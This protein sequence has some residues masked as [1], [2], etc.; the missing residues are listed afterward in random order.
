MQKSITICFIFASIFFM[1]CRDKGKDSSSDPGPATT[2]EPETE[3]PVTQYGTLVLGELRG[4]I[5]PKNG[6]DATSVSGADI[7]ALEHSELVGKTGADGAFVISNTAPGTVSLMITSNDTGGSLRLNGDTNA[8]YGLKFDD[9]TITSG[10]STDLGVTQFKETGS[11]SG[12][13]KYYNNPNNLDLTGAEVFVP[14]T[15]YIAKTDAQGEFKISGLPEGKYGLRAQQTG[16]SVLDLV[17]VEVKEAS[18]TKLGTITLSLS[19]GPEGGISSKGDATAIISQK[20]YEIFKSKSITVIL[21][22][23]GDAALMKLSDEPAFLNKSWLPVAKTFP[24]T[25]DSDGFKTIYVQY[26]DLNGLESSPFSVEL[27][28]DTTVP[29]LTGISL[30]HDWLE[31]GQLKSIV[32]V[33]ASDNGSGVAEIMFSNS[34]ANFNSGEVWQTYTGEQ[35]T[36]NIAS[37]VD[38]PR[39]VYVRVRDFAGNISTTATDD[40]TKGPFTIIKNKTYTK[41]VHL[42]KDQSP[43]TIPSSGIQIVTDLT[44]D[45]DVEIDLQTRTFETKAKVTAVGT[46]TKRIRIKNGYLISLYSLVGVSEASGYS[47]VTFDNATVRVAGGV[48]DNCIFDGTDNPYTRNFEKY[49]GDLLI[50]KNS[51]FMKW[52]EITLSY[53]AENVRLED[54]QA[55]IVTWLRVEGSGAVSKRNQLT[56]QTGI[57]GALVTVRNGTVTSESDVMNVSSNGTAYSTS[58]GA[59][60][61]ATP[62]LNIKNPTINNCKYAFHNNTN[63]DTVSTTTVNGGTVTGCSTLA[64]NEDFD[65]G[66]MQIQN[67]TATNLTYAHANDV[68]ANG[69]VNIT[70]SDIRV[71]RALGYSVAN[72]MTLNVSN[73]IV[74]CEDDGTNPCDLLLSTDMGGNPAYGTLTLTNNKIV[75][76]GD[77]VSGCRGFTADKLN[78]STT[79]DLN[80]TLSGNFWQSGAGIKSMIPASFSA[81]VTAA[82]PTA[83]DIRAYK[84]GFTTVDGGAWPPVPSPVVAEGNLLGVIGPQ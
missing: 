30:M 17:D 44:I 77:T 36:W 35:M 32:D 67:L 12:T 16:F 7:A 40:I 9:V 80:I 57:T 15:G 46:A 49:G 45:P 78:S 72:G 10:K 74:T 53:N 70:Q 58:L 42:T 39:D 41:P 20:T 81:E 24:W 62:I 13:I 59:S 25:F 79:A 11:L 84:I 2:T 83:A 71:S 48:F 52:N 66:V 8:K 61:G 4:Q 18:D 3:T 55:D 1:S 65:D 21:D 56:Q 63:G 28:V 27:V 31:I 37:G 34:S 5:T 76:Y 33:F 29:T 51:H 38:G 82:T 47:Y 14:G 64:K 22:Y 43:Y 50:V 73:S 6:A 23:D 68:G 19:D 60:L 26:S 69:S 54:N 75:C